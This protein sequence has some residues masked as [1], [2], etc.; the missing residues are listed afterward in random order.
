MGR[1]AERTRRFLAKNPICCFCGGVA[2]ASTRDHVPS[3]AFFLNRK[4]PE[5]FE[6]PACSLCNQVTAL[7]EQLA[8]FLCRVRI[9]ATPSEAQSTELTKL[10]TGIFNNFPGLLARMQV[11]EDREREILAQVGFDGNGKGPSEMPGILSLDD[12]RI[13]EA[14]GQFAVKLFCALHYREV[15]AIVS[16]SGGIAFRWWSNYE[17]MRAGVPPEIGSVLN[18]FGETKRAKTSLGE[19]FFYRFGVSTSGKMAVYLAVFNESTALIGTVAENSKD[20]DPSM[21]TPLLRPWRW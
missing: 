14:M 7:N 9:D 3:R 11:P 15:G 13:H 1:A 21:N 12:D 5:G 20:F 19:Q 4:W 6:F 16:H 8:A 10:L 17:V 2:E 18:Q